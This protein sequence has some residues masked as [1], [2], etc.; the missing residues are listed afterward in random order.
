MQKD[1]LRSYHFPKVHPGKP[2]AFRIP[3]TPDIGTLFEALSS[4][5]QRKRPLE[6]TVVCF[7]LFVPL[8]HKLVD[9]LSSQLP[10]TQRRTPFAIVS[11]KYT[12]QRSTKQIVGIVALMNGKV[13]DF[14]VDNAE[15][16][17]V[18]EIV[19]AELP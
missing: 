2:I 10:A 9:D 6:I 13:Q 8:M 16:K 14:A 7:V 19:L 17:N 18:R 1:N 3:G 4:S 11:D 5:G 12:A 15:V